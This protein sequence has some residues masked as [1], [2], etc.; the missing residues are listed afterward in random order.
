MTEK[1]PPSV[2]DT[3]AVEVG[4][5]VVA[6]A[7]A[8]VPQK[9]SVTRARE[10]EERLKHIEDEL[11]ERNMNI[12]RDVAAF[13]E[14]DPTSDEP[15]EAWVLEHGREEAIK[16]HR[17]ARAAW[18]SQTEAPIAIRIAKDI[19]IGITKARAAEKT[20]PRQLNVQVV[21]MPSTINVNFGEEIEVE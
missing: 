1:R 11:L 2:I 12:V 5:S 7:L 16:R 3:D 19:A 13:R 8:T 6:D 4:A 10:R 18:M 14:I 15:P 9:K 17:V 20:G 21:Q